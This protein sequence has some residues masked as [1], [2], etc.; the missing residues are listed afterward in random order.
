M[1]CLTT[2]V[3]DEKYSMYTYTEYMEMLNINEPLHLS[4]TECLT[5]HLMTDFPD[6]KITRFHIVNREAITTEIVY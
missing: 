4:Y 6:S 3:Q 5:G 1:V 2:T